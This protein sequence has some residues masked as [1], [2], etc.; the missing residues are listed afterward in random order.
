MTKYAFLIG[1]NNYSSDPD[2]G[3]PGLPPL[4]CAVNDVVAITGALKNI[5]GFRDEEITLMTC[6][7]GARDPR[8]PSR[9]N[10]LKQLE[11]IPRQKLDSLLIIFCGHGFGGVNSSG[12][13]D[14]YLCPVNAEQST[15]ETSAISLR[16]LTETVK[17]IGA[18]NTCVILDCCQNLPG[19]RNV[20]VRSQQDEDLMAACTRDIQAVARPQRAR[21]RKPT[22]IFMN[23]CSVNQC[24]YEWTTQGHGIFTAYLLKA[25]KRSGRVTDWIDLIG[26]VVYDKAQELYGREQHPYLRVEGGRNIY[27][28]MVKTVGDATAKTNNGAQAD[29]PVPPP[30]LEKQA[31]DRVV[32]AIKE[33]EYPFRWCPPGTFM[34]GS[35]VSE[36]NRRNNETQHQVTLTKG[37]WLLETPV[38]QAMWEGVMGNNPSHFKNAKWPVIRVSWDGCQ[39]YIQKLNNLSVAQGLPVFVADGGA[40]GICLSCRNDNAVPFRLCPA[41]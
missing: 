7:P 32:L 36:K 20:V 31:G 34:M 3:N 13:Y 40:M 28:P 22:T 29:K 12:M 24:A 38:T 8:F 26:E 17:A 14:L 30:P 11:K 21:R 5:Y 2:S 25:M 4:K 19:A 9:K 37:F 33:I 41:R 15:L 35:P 39:D 10:I 18:M 23:S 1:I 6:S 16:L 27:F